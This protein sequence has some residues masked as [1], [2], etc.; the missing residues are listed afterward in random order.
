MIGEPINMKKE[1]LKST[2]AIAG[3]VQTIVEEKYNKYK[4]IEG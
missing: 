3:F 1:E 4:E 2:V